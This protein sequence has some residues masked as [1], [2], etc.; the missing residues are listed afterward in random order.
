VKDEGGAELAIFL[1]SLPSARR[2]PWIRR[3]LVGMW[4]RL[5]LFQAA[6]LTK[7]GSL[8]PGLASPDPGKSAKTDVPT[9]ILDLDASVSFRDSVCLRIAVEND[10]SDPRVTPPAPFCREYNTLDNGMALAAPGRY[11][12]PWRPTWKAGAWAGQEG[13]STVKPE[14]G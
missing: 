8:H 9:D 13:F 3:D 2:K 11:G 1:L 10:C 4:S 5:P 7:T 12:M 6:T 14:C